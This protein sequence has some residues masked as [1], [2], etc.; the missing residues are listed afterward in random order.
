M[1]RPSTDSKKVP[2][3]LPQN[4]LVLLD[5]LVARRLYGETRSEVARHLIVTALAAMVDKGRLVE[6]HSN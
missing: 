1:A 5:Q 2:I 6:P 4:A 3:T